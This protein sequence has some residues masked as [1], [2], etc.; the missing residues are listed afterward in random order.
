M[1]GYGWNILACNQLFMPTG[2]GEDSMFIPLTWNYTEYTETCQ[3]LYG[4]TPEYD[5]ALTYFG[6]YNISLDFMAATNIVWSN[7]EL[8]PWRAGGLNANVSADGS[9][10]ALYI[11]EAAHHLDLRPP[12][13]DD[14]A[15][16]T[17]ARNIE[18]ANIKKWIA[19]YQTNV[20]FDP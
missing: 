19:E 10:I 14:P 2:F 8:D 16:V 1:D 20:A 13:V 11:A 6:G 5:W 3:K 7:G 18:M 4:L 9:S 15:S 17:E 12:N